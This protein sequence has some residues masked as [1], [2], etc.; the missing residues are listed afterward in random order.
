MPRDLAKRQAWE[1][2]YRETKKERAREY[3]ATPERRAARAAYKATPAGAE[4]DKRYRQGPAGTATRKRAALA[5]K[6]GVVADRQSAVS[7]IKTASGCVDCGYKEHAIA[8]DFDHVSGEKIDNVSKMV[9]S[10]V[11]WDL[12]IAEIAKCEVVCANCHRV[13]TKLGHH[14][15]NA[16]K[17]RRP[18][19]LTQGALFAVPEAG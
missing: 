17:A 6:Q 5:V 1:A 10:L 2:Q 8:L 7:A 3:D 12:V 4:A 9:K 13:R 14:Y 15:I 16:R 19:D 11:T 18:N